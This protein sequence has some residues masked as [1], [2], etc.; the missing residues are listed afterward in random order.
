MT[1]EID[2]KRNVTQHYGVRTTDSSKGAQSKGTGNVKRAQWDWSWDNLPVAG[3]TN[4]EY[5]IPAGASIISATLIADSA[6]DAIMDVGTTG[7]LVGFFNDVDLAT[8]GEVNVS[9]GALVGAKLATA[10]ELV[11]SSAA[12]T[13]TARLIVEFVYDK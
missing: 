6:W 9:S 10:L 5:A 7:S 13:G 11:V 3:A 12:T 8:D 2:A 4:L 1:Y